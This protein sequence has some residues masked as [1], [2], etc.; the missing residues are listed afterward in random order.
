MSAPCGNELKAVADFFSI[1]LGFDPKSYDKQDP[2]IVVTLENEKQA[3]QITSRTVLVRSVYNY[4]AEGTSRE[5]LY[6]NIKQLKDTFKEA[7]CSPSRSFKINIESYNLKQDFQTIPKRL[8]ELAE[9]ANLDLQGPVSLS[10]PDVSFYFLEYYGSQGTKPLAKKLYFGTWVADGQKHL[11]QRYDLKKRHYIGNT[12]MDA[13][14]SLLVSNLA[15]AGPGSWVLD[16]FVGTGSLLVAC[17]H[18]GAYVTGTDIDYKII[19]GF[20]KSSSH[21]KKFRGPDENFL[22]NL[23]QY[24][25][26]DLYLDVLVGDASKHAMWRRS[27]LFDAIVTD[28]PYGIREYTV[29]IDSKKR[30]PE[31]KIQAQ[32]DED[33]DMVEKGHDVCEK[34]TSYAG[35]QKSDYQLQDIVKDLLNF[36]AK[37]LKLGGHLVYWLPVYRPDYTEEMVPSHPC[38]KLI[39]NCEQT[40]TLKMSRRLITMQK[41]REDTELLDAAHIPEML[42][43]ERL[44]DKY[45]EANPENDKKKKKKKKHRGAGECDTESVNQ[46]T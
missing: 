37:F 1:Q 46:P 31:N 19:H 24:G 16:P 29:K 28:P 17:A 18:Y 32:E 30:N 33:I 9:H 23:R 2:F 38:L 39:S 34:Q 35:S 15:L 43:K 41:C 40:I 3:K 4:W 12:S 14:L 27:S 6:Q 36:A 8:Q 44:R 10:S 20:G 7:Y 5:E 42:Y 25:L 26:E 22:A 45:F 11:V 21:K 13:R